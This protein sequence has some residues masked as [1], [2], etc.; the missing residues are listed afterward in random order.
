MK[1]GQDIQHF[2]LLSSL[3]KGGMGEVFLARD[4]RLGRNVALKF[5]AEEFCSQKDHVTRFVREARAA[6]S[7]NHPNVCTIHEISDSGP[8]PFI[9]MEYVEGETLAQMI[10]RNR[11][12]ANQAIAIALQAA[13]ALAEAHR[14]GLVHRDVKPANIIV[15]PLGRVKLLDFGLAKQV[16][17]G[18]GDA[19]ELGIT[20]EGMI[21]GTASYMSPEQT[22]GREVDERTD[23]WSLGVTMY[24]MLSGIHPF[25]GETIVDTLAAILTREPERLE[26]LVPGIRPALSSLI[27]SCMIKDPAAR[28][29]SCTELFAR[30]REV[31]DE[32]K[33]SPDPVGDSPGNGTNDEPTELIELATTELALEKVTGEE[34]RRRNLRPNN[35]PERFGPILGREREIAEVARILRDERTRLVTLTGVGGT[36]KTRLSE[37]VGEELLADLQDGVFLVELGNVTDKDLICQQ[38]ADSLGIEDRR[39]KPAEELLTEHLKARSMLLIIDNF[40]QVVDGAGELAKLIDAS[41]KLKLLVT[42]RVILNLS[43]EKEYLVPPLELPKGDASPEVLSSN[44]AVRLFIERAAAVRPG[45]EFTEKNAE[46]IGRIC[47]RLEGLPLA[48]ELAAARM[49][50]LSPTVILE[51][52]DEGLAI[53]GGGAGDLPERQRTMRGMVRW[54]Y[55]L[56]GKT[57]QSFFRM[58][59]VFRGGFRLEAAEEVCGPLARASG[60]ET[61]ELLSSLV[62]KSLIT[63]RE[64]PGG[65]LRFHLLEV[66]REFAAEELENAKEATEAAE[67]HAVFFAGL[68]ETLEPEVQSGEPEAFRRLEEDHD[69]FRAALRWSLASAPAVGVR[70][71]VALR[72]FWIL[73]G[74]LNEGSQWLA[75]ASEA[76]EPPANLRFKLMNGLGL[77]ARFRGDLETARKAYIAGL[78][79]GEEAGDKAGIAISCRGL[80]LVLYQSKELEDARANFERGLEISRELKD[81]LGIAMS[82]S[83]L[84]D[85]HRARGNYEEASDPIENSVEIFRRIGRRAALA[86]ALNNL[87]TVHLSGSRRTRAFECFSEAFDIATEL[88]NKITTSHCLDG[89]AAIAVELGD[90]SMAARFA[91]AA[92]AMRSAVGYEIEPAEAH[93]RESIIEKMRS[94]LSADEFSRQIELGRNEDSE[95]LKKSISDLRRTQSTPETTAAI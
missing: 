30:L 71:A 47:S 27:A 7:L 43:I 81:D 77:A 35:L 42:S 23:V 3:G 19:E 88:G 85:L 92:D 39:G 51:K 70:L 86:D 68:A 1:P 80:G 75:A 9:A 25:A 33:R 49:R 95:A 11:R 17:R 94:S 28:L 16:A 55:D 67:S 34:I 84:G 53:L 14:S 91:G 15:T 40:E 45:F 21:V 18:L 89:F 76:G 46:K 57:E 24:E 26:N 36:G 73:H 10:V 31:E 50:I 62:E 48:I 44:P 41:E 56:L 32:L 8:R 83:F 4:N 5:L 66:V 20:R 74:H 58:L 13:D 78:A 65:E 12:G 37:A 90:H 2:T 52:L 38:I 79:A 64:L 93:F 72:N 22:R 59:S 29:G 63:K 54:S 69:N 60:V 82:L 61:F 87:G 6:S